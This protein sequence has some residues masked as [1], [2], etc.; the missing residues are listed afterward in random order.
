MSRWRP[1]ALRG[2][3]AP[4]CILTPRIRQFGFPRTMVQFLG[5]IRMLRQTPIPR[6]VLALATVALLLAGCGD[7][8]TPPPPPAPLPPPPPP[9]AAQTLTVVVGAGV[10]GSPASGQVSVPGGTA[11]DYVFTL[12]SGYD[13]ITVSVDG[14][15]RPVVGRITMDRSHLLLAGAVPRAIVPPQDSLTRSV[16]RVNTAAAPAP[17][18]QAALDQLVVLSDQAG[19]NAAMTRAASLLAHAPA[20]L[21]EVS[22]LIRVNA[23]LAGRTFEVVGGPDVNPD[24]APPIQAV[25]GVVTPVDTV[26]PTTLVFVNG[27]WNDYSKALESMTRLMAV[28]TNRGLLSGGG[29]TRTMGLALVYNPSAGSL[30]NTAANAQCFLT[31]LNS[32]FSPDRAPT[33]SGGLPSSCGVLIDVQESLQQYINIV[34]DNAQS[35]IAAPSETLIGEINRFRVERKHNVILVG[36]SQGTMVIREALSRLSS[37]NTSEVG[38]V[39]SINVA[40]PVGESGWPGLQNPVV[41]RI[42][43]GGISQDILASIVPGP[44]FPGIA[45]ERTLLWDVVI[46]ALDLVGS[47]SLGVI[48][49]VGAGIDLHGFNTYASTPRSAAWLGDALV[50]TY[51]ELATACAGRLT[52]TVEDASTGMPIAGATVALQLAGQTIATSQTASNGIFLT[53]S[54]RARLYD[55]RASA[56]GYD[57]VIL[58]RQRILPR[59]TRTSESVRLVRSA[60]A[61][62]AVSGVIRDARNLAPLAGALVEIRL[63]QNATGGP[64]LASVTTLSTGFFRFFNFPAGSYTLAV[65]RNGYDRAVRTVAVIGG[66]ETGNQDVVTYPAGFGSQVGIILT[67][68][69]TPSDLDAHLTGPLASGNRFH[70]AWFS[71]GNLT[72]EPFAKLDVDDRSSFGPE[73][74]TIASR[75][76]GVY[77]YSIHDFSNRSSTASGALATSGATVILS[78]PGQSTRTFRVPNAPGNLWTVFELDGTQLTPI[79]QMS[80]ISSWGVV[81]VG[82]F[83]TEGLTLTPGQE[84][85]LRGLMDREKPAPVPPRG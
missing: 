21:A 62:G 31:L 65:T 24:L 16:Q 22:T 84:E 30:T 42:A 69:A 85:I 73:T 12:N 6:S 72:D 2:R 18:F 67:W 50:Q 29:P 81:P 41:G 47:R 11:V 78:I 49:R 32:A 36:H 8:I 45:T 60:S 43:K 61:V 4:I 68:G 10:T 44:K 56:P 53:P 64:A 37:Q 63:G 75:R 82:P 70:I 17:A 51:Q 76:P 38:C 52:G 13:S 23:A 9:A 71:F 59:S 40:S 28:A 19:P 25:P 14:I 33:Q 7:G 74:V 26:T 54:N 80:F 77:R 20:T 48:S 55:L 58:E 66:T 35:Q 15:L 1:P 79:N 3:H 27:I 57:P 5:V 39:G 46:A 83:G 34:L